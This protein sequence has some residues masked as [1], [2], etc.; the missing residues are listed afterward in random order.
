MS[1]ALYVIVIIRL[2]N[3]SVWWCDFQRRCKIDVH[4]VFIQG[5]PHSARDGDPEE[6][7]PEPDRDQYR[8]WGP[9]LPLSLHCAGHPL[10]NIPVVI[11]RLKC[12]FASVL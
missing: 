8:G 3:F 1:T 7:R 6:G 4:G 9:V 10:T 11:N 5:D 2:N 12:Y